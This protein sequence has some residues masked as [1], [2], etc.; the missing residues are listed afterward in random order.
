MTYSDGEIKRT[1]S[2]IPCAK[3]IIC[4]SRADEWSLTE[5]YEF[6]WTTLRRSTADQL[7]LSG[8]EA[9]GLCIGQAFIIG[10][11]GAKQRDPPD[12]NCF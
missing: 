7:Q 12:S 8:N 10:T 5:Q 11:S 9:I 6:R 1:V 2:L 4:R 3:G